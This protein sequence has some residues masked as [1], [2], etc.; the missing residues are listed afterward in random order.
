MLSAAGEHGVADP[1]RTFFMPTDADFPVR[2]FRRWYKKRAG[3]SPDWAEV[4]KSLGSRESKEGWWVAN[5]ESGAGDV[6]VTG[7]S[8]SLNISSSLRSRQGGDY[9][10]ITLEVCPRRSTS[11]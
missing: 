7:V 9:Y 3:G 2:A 6:D 1:E 11:A 10:F 8:R 5:P 4:R